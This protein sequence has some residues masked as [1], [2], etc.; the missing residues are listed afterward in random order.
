MIYK[1]VDSNGDKFKPSNFLNS[2]NN[3]YVNLHAQRV[4]KN[5]GL[6]KKLN[7]IYILNYDPNVD[8]CFIKS[9]ICE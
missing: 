5:L 7:C 4:D 2:K 8:R 6:I 9:A 1:L 3:S